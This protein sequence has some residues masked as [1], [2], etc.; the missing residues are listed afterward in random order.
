MQVDK[1]DVQNNQRT[2]FKFY[3]YIVYFIYYVTV[4]F[5]LTISL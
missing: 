2:F 1:W 4:K 3:S 5:T